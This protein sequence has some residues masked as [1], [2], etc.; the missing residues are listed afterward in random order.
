MSK[1][2][3]IRIGL[4]V[5]FALLAWLAQEFGLSDSGSIGKTLPSAET[6]SAQFTPVQKSGAGM[7]L[8]EGCRLISGRNS[9]GDSF[10]VRHPKGETEFRLYFVDTPESAYKEYGGGE[11]NGKRLREQGEAFGGLSQEDTTTVGRTAKKFV[12]KLLKQG[13]FAVLT[14]WENVYGPDRKY[15]LVVVNWQGE[16]VYLHE[17]LV[18]QGLGRIHTRGADLPG[19]RSWKEQK[20]FLRGFEQAARDEKLGGWS[21]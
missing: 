3:L 16:E 1:K 21:F 8:L 12:Q 10:H 5:L 19:G 6:V 2:R 14:K 18:A 17:L 15:A 13:D 20:T 4:A 11:N 7:E 9:D